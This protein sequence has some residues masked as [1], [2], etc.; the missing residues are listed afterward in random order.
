MIEVPKTEVWSDWTALSARFVRR[1]LQDCERIR[2]VIRRKF[3][4]R[5]F[6]ADIGPPSSMAAIAVE[7]ARTGRELPH[8]ANLIVRTVQFGPAEPFFPSL[9]CID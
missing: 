2:A 5:L 6:R 9:C 3:T 8:L 4:L 1:A 7:V